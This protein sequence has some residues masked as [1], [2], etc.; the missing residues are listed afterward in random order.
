MMITLYH[1]RKSTID[2]NKL[3]I[4]VL[5]K[6]LF[7]HDY[8]T[9]KTNEYIY[10]KNCT[11]ILA[12]SLQLTLLLSWYISHEVMYKLVNFWASLRLLKAILSQRTKALR[13][14][15]TDNMFFFRKWSMPNKPVKTHQLLKVIS[16]PVF[17]YIQYIT[18]RLFAYNFL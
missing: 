12:N 17:K 1:S 11:N 2:Q 15:K 13:M 14:L 6:T 3:Q 9:H 7:H 5:Y 10:W 16:F 4:C 18:C 8:C